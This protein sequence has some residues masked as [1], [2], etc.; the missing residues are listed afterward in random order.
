MNPIGSEGPYRNEEEQNSPYAPC[1]REYRKDSVNSKRSLKPGTI[2]SHMRKLQRHRQSG[3]GI[4]EILVAMV[5]L[6][7]LIMGFTQFMT[8]T[9]KGMKQ[10]DAKGEGQNF[11][12]TARLALAHQDKCT[13]ALGLDEAS[14]NSQVKMTIGDLSGSS[15]YT[16][17]IPSLTLL[18]KSY[19][20]GTEE[21][22]L[23]VS[24]INL[25][26][27]QRPASEIAQTGTGFVSKIRVEF[28]PVNTSLKQLP[29]V[30][31]TTIL[32]NAKA[33]GATAAS[34]VWGTSCYA[35]SSADP[36]KMCEQLGGRWLRNPDRSKS[37]TTDAPTYWIASG[38]PD[39]T[40]HYMPAERCSLAGEIVL[41]SNE[42]PV[43]I[44]IKGG[45]NALGE[46]VETCFYE[47]AGKVQS[48]KCPGGSG[49]RTGHR[50]IFDPESRQ[51]QRRYF[52]GK[53]VRTAHIY[54]ICSKGVKISM[55]S[56]ET[57]TLSF[58]EPL[59]TAWSES[60]AGDVTKY[61]DHLNTVEFCVKNPDNDNP[62]RCINPD[63]PEGALAGKTGACVWVKNSKPVGAT[64]ATL[65]KFDPPQNTAGPY[66]GWGLIQSSTQA[67][68]GITAGAKTGN[69]R[70]ARV[71]PCHTV[72]VNTAA[73]VDPSLTLSDISSQAASVPALN[74]ET[75]PD[76][77]KQCVYQAP[78]TV[79]GAIEK[80]VYSCNNEG[81]NDKP[82]E[83]WVGVG[84]DP[85]ILGKGHC[86]Y[87]EDVRIAG[88]MPGTGAVQTYPGVATSFTAATGA[89]G[90]TY[91]GWVYM[92]GALADNKYRQ[93]SGT[94][95]IEK[96][97]GNVTVNG[98]PC[99]G[100]VRIAPPPP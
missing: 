26:V 17:A 34:N 86:W 95:V 3:F 38:D 71:T 73:Y 55:A 36:K 69:L 37:A 47:S 92:E 28:L 75:T 84:T 12:T 45:S 98:I 18:G 70:V 11:Q 48:Y 42:A 52:N 60:W 78:A 64:A 5:G 97:S 22:M 67:A 6:G 40:D 43:G 16:K 61:W 30:A 59:E 94:N 63:N 51:W 68:P 91:T 2:G 23:K 46:R 15:I 89:A 83:D 77:V 41:A 96:A 9:Q 19:S 90:R 99:T 29:A 25:I 65:A 31:E 7:I 14:A 53:G 74:L 79:G 66:T 87:F 4:A 81:L 72:R 76:L 54:A 33:D 100:G 21:G 62:V 13:A 50:C 32:L 8:S 57:E 27:N 58:D 44:P 82:I 85:T 49:T 88:Y 10:L 24:S 80:T 1:E 20:V 39:W 35:D 93:K 56:P